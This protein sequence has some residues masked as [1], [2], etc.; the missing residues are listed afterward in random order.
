MI[1]VNKNYYKLFEERQ[2]ETAT[3]IKN[4]SIVPE[5]TG[6]ENLAYQQNP[7]NIKVCETITWIFNDLSIHTVTQ[8]NPSINVPTNGFDSCLISPE[9]TFTAF[10]KNGT[11]EYHC[12]LHPTML[13]K[14][15]VVV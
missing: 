15:I 5:A 4:I 2:N 1:Y 8:G 9:E 11:I 14:V 6:L 12:T 10:D 7:V 3:N 13:G